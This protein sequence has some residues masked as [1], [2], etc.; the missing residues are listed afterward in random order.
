MLYL[1][2][3]LELKPHFFKIIFEITK[4]KKMSFSRAKREF[5]MESDAKRKSGLPGPQTYDPKSGRVSI[6]FLIL[7]NFSTF[8]EPFF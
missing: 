6:F 8:F 1:S 4:N 5:F 7:R 3:E 2:A